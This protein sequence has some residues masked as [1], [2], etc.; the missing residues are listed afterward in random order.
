MKKNLSKKLAMSVAMFSLAIC[1]VGCQMPSARNTPGNQAGQSQDAIVENNDNIKA[2]EDFVGIKDIASMEFRLDDKAGGDSKKNDIVILERILEMKN[3]SQIIAFADILRSPGKE[4]MRDSDAYKEALKN[5]E[6]F[7]K[8]IKQPVDKTARDLIIKT[9]KENSSSRDYMRDNGY[10]IKDNNELKSMISFKSASGQKSDLILEKGY[11]NEEYL[12][13]N[14]KGH[15]IGLTREDVMFIDKILAKSQD[16]GSLSQELEKYVKDKGDYV[17]YRISKDDVKMPDRLEEPTYGDRKKLYLA[18]VDNMLKHTDFKDGLDKY[19]GQ[20]LSF[21]RYRL[22]KEANKERSYEER[23]LVAIYSGDKLVGAYKSDGGYISSFEGKDLEKLTKVKYKDWVKDKM[24]HDKDAVDLEKLGPEG[25]VRKYV[26][27]ENARDIKQKGL[28]LP[29]YEYGYETIFKDRLESH[30]NFIDNIISAKL[31]SIK[32]DDYIKELENCDADIAY[33]TKIDYQYK[34]VIV[35][36]SGI[37]EL[38]FE[39]VDLGPG[40]GYRINNRGY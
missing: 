13:V 4:D 12:L 34:E 30:T 20:T 8:L 31:L 11:R 18:Y 40:L 15:V 19:L 36:E 22:K 33:R 17:K 25:I 37:D 38:S 23:Y 29:E 7:D 32:P 27:L 16:I 3:K 39:L 10:K 21:E 9:L 24:A 2:L 26:D 1:Q 6:D 28:W 14:K 5:K 35:K